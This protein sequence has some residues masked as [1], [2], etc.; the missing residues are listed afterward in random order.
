ML[1]STT[2]S[3][4][5]R[6]WMVIVLFAVF[7]G[8]AS[9]VVLARTNTP[10]SS[11]FF[12]DTDTGVDDAVA[13]A[14]LLRAPEA[15]IVGITTVA[16]N[17]TVENATNNVLSLLDVA[18]PSPAIPVTIGAAAPLQVPLTRVGA[19]V[20]GP[21]GLWFAGSQH[22][23]DALNDDA[24]AAIAAAARANPGLVILALGPL[25]NIAEAAERFPADLANARII[26]LAGAKVGGNRT[27][28]AETNAFIDPDALQQLLQH[29]LDVTL[30]TWD[31]WSKV[32]VDSVAFPRLI[33]K[34]GAL[35]QFLAGPLATYG[36]AQTQGAGGPMTIPDAVAALYALKPR[37]ELATSALVEVVTDTGATRGQT[38][39]AV[40]VPERI[41][42]IA[43][44]EEMSALADRVF[45][46]PTFNQAEA[47]GAIL[48]RRPDNAQVVLS[49]GNEFPG[50]FR[51][52]FTGR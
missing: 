37:P 40:T 36:Q 9:D 34:A 28:V 2:T 32:T 13:L 49:L 33:A 25:T 52:K 44:D 18:K 17:T 1:T 42:L 47:I 21:D 7:A 38:I 3:R 50:Q 11:T 23:L 27:A 10:S 46:D 14:L 26:A 43:N 20:H 4:L 31:A 35:G 48:Q 5:A 45:S 41:S 30:V 19:F 8:S 6:L 12:V 15:K 39:I 22:N 29:Q 51:S 24:P 16:G